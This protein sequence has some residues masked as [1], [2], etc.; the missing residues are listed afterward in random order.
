MANDMRKR[1]W[2]LALASGA[3]LILLLVLVF[4]FVFKQ[5]EEQDEKLEP[6]LLSA[7][8]FGDRTI[9]VTFQGHLEE[10][11]AGDFVIAASTRTWDDL[12]NELNE[13]IA[14]TGVKAL[15]VGRNKTA[16]ILELDA[17][18]HTDGTLKREVYRGMLPLLTA[19]KY[20]SYDMNM[21]MVKADRLLTWQTPAGGWDQGLHEQ[22]DPKDEK[23]VL[24]DRAWDGVEPRSRWRDAQD[25]EAGTLANGATVNEMILLAKVYRETGDRR[26][27]EA[28]LQALDYLL[29]MQYPQGGWP[30]VYP[31]MGNEADLVTFEGE[32]MIRAMR[33][34]TMVHEGRYPFDYAWLDAGRKEQIQAAL[35]KGLEFILQSQLQVEEQLAGWAKRYDPET[36]QPVSTSA[37]ASDAISLRETIDIVKYLMSIEAKTPTVHTALEGALHFLKQVDAADEEVQQSIVKLVHIAETTGYYE[38]QVYVRYVGAG[39]GDAETLVRVASQEPS[40]QRPELQ[41][42]AENRYAQQVE[43]ELIAL[44]EIEAE[45]ILIVAQDES[46]DYSDVQ[47]AVD[48][49]PEHN[50][51]PVT[52]YIKKG[53]YKQKVVV[54]KTKPYITF[55]GES[56]YQT[57]LTHLEITG[58][59]FNGNSTIIE[60]DDFTAK[61]LTFAN[62]AGAIGTAAAVEVRGDRGFFDGVRFIGYQDTLYINSKNGGRFYF[63]NCYIE[64]AVDFIYGPGTAFFDHCVIFNKRSEGY[65]TAA[66]TPQEQRYG[67]IFYHCTI[68]GYPWVKNV[69]FGRP[70]RDYANAVFLYSWIDEG[71]INLQGWHNWGSTEKE[72]TARYYEYASYGPGANIRFRAKWVKQLTR[73]EA[74]EYTLEHVLAGDDGWNPLN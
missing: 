13:E 56:K 41:P 45:K 33:L 28:L 18:L 4:L 2:L 25:Q 3:L 44:D 47:S 8:V 68:T 74:A 73:E 14:I 42:I 40:L 70:W 58:T 63:R 69:Y 27:K 22:P 24:I 20:Y 64:G 57:V 55:I 48:A 11:D 15:H 37:E 67:L 12:N 23:K 65:I 66:S 60:A 35:N 54:P 72:K 39:Q 71:M 46:G 6:R 10:V 62:E 52:I 5:K 34:L 21:N 31:L 26:Y 9:Q 19:E 50:T 61:N 43:D 32:A 36:L 59:G 53:I 17:S 16:V 38:D 1:G 29:A 7:E 49:V 51:E 30:L